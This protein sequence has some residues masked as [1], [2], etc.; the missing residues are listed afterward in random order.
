MHTR[1]QCVSSAH[2]RKIR[3]WNYHNKTVGRKITSGVNK[4]KN[5]VIP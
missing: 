3:L 5:D 4:I 2:L 1:K